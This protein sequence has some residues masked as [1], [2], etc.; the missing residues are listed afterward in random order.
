MAVDAVV[1]GGGTAFAEAMLLT[2][3]GVSGPSILQVLIFLT[4]TFV[5]TRLRPAALPARK[6]R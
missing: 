2:H 1:K 4:Y 6:P 5:L 3:R